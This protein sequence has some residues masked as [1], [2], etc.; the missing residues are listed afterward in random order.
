MKNYSNTKG[1]SVVICC[2]NSIGKLLPTLDALASQRFIDSNTFPVEILIVDNAST[3]NTS[4]FAES[5]LS[6]PD[7]G[8]EYRVLY[9]ARP[10]KTF[11]LSYGIN[12]AKYSYVCVVDD[13]NSLSADYLDI[14]WGILEAN[15]QIGVLGG[16]GEPVLEATAPSWFHKFAICYAASGQAEKAGDLTTTTRFVYGA[17]S[18]LRKS[19]WDKIHRAGFKFL[20]TGNK[21]NQLTS[22]EDN[23][24]CYALIIAGYKIWYDGRLKFKHH[25]P[26]QRLTWNYVRK[27]FQAFAYT[28]ATLRPYLDYLERMEHGLTSPLGLAKPFVWIRT[29]RSMLKHLPDMY[30]RTKLDG[31]NRFKEGGLHSMYTLCYRDTIIFMLKK[32]LDGN[33][34]FEQVQQFITKVQ[35]LD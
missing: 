34:D 5:I 7:F 32:E 30:R 31:V 24:L 3:D 18:V 26:A 10:G 28:A 21:G 27:L 4:L 17:G 9:E 13:D 14:A 12:E 22:G 29:A 6:S 25:I 15:P 20:L 2:Y 8:F 1:I 23:E 35:E 19:A 16:C 11:A 33:K